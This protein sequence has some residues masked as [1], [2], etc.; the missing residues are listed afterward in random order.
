MSFGVFQGNSPLDASPPLGGAARNFLVA[1]NEA[2]MRL[3]AWRRQVD[4]L[5]LLKVAATERFRDPAV[6]GDLW[7]WNEQWHRTTGRVIEW[8]HR[9]PVGG[10]RLP[11]FEELNDVVHEAPSLEAGWRH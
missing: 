2:P 1:A 3:A 4:L 9:A 6:S 10:R 8:A 7:A 5:E 11:A